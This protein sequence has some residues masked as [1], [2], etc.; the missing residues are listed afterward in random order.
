MWP[1]IAG[2]IAWDI[3][4][5]VVV[6]LIPGLIIIISYSK[7]LQITKKSRRRL[8]ASMAYSKR[9]HIQVS[10]QDFKLLRTLFVLM[11][12]FFV[13]WS[14]IIIFILLILVQKF[15][16]D[17]AILPSVFFWIMAFT[18]ANSVVNPVLYNAVHF[19]HEWRR[20]F[21]CCLGQSG[22]NETTPDTT[23]RH[24]NNGPLTLSVISR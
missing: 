8:H 3:S 2:E 19:R 12:S 17:L 6:F 5:A 23:S 4:F 24:N 15:H 22:R 20:V 10:R 9:N 21:F 7:I 13:M 1:S 16:P 14:P 11:I 18:F